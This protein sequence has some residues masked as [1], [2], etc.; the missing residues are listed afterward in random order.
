MQDTSATL[1]RASKIIRAFIITALIVNANAYNENLA[2]TFD[3]GMCN[4]TTS[5]DY[6]WTRRSGLTHMAQQVLAATIPLGM[7][8]ICM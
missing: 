6:S 4:F 7:A 8:T 2:C 1:S 3:L 5:V